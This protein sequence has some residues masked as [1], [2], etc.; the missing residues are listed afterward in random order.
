[1]R[2]INYVVDDLVCEFPPLSCCIRLPELSL[3]SAS[4]GGSNI[5]TNE[6]NACQGPRI[7]PRNWAHH[8]SMDG[9][10]VDTTDILT[11]EQEP[12]RC[13][14]PVVRQSSLLPHG[15]N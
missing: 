11:A 10:T 6:D 15:V 3:A 14:P 13:L 12:R 9:L 4:E 1:M 2:S 7:Y 5:Q 8:D